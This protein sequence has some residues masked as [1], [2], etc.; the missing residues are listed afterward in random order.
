M[1]HHF[2]TGG[3]NR[4]KTIL[5]NARFRTTSLHL[6][7]QKR[8]LVVVVRIF[9]LPILFIL[10][11]ISPSVLLEN[12]GLHFEEKS[13]WDW[14]GLAIQR[15][16]SFFSI[17]LCFFG[18]RTAL[19]RSSFSSFLCVFSIFLLSSLKAI[20]YRLETFRFGVEGVAPLRQR[21]T[22]S[23][24]NSSHPPTPAAA[25]QWPASGHRSFSFPKE[26][27]LLSEN[28]PQ[29]TFSAELLTQ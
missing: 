6:L 22:N 13:V 12:T 17:L 16:P 25:A 27:S 8:S 2:E 29:E 28:A 20:S 14:T 5:L 7:I 23:R 19:W 18:A 1:K 15:T 3:G 21:Q 4:V 26:I 24:Y 11:T 9:G 10:W